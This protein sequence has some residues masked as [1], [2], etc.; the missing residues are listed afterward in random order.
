[1]AL[2][3]EG[4]GFRVCVKTRVW[5]S[6]SWTPAFAGVTGEDPTL[7]RAHGLALGSVTICVISRGC[8]L[9]LATSANMPR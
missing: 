1:M 2:L 8:T 6:P 9:T 5:R 3:R 7:L 4:Q